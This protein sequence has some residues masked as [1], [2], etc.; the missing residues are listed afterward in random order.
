MPKTTI[1]IEVDSPAM[2]ILEGFDEDDQDRIIK[3]IETELIDLFQDR[4][5]EISIN[6]VEI[7]KILDD[8]GVVLF[9]Q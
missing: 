4:A 8:D 5:F 6:N 7:T 2:N 9:E 3:H 1:T